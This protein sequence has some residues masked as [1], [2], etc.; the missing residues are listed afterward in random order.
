MQ[1]AR[2]PL[3]HLAAAGVSG[4]EKEDSTAMDLHDKRSLGGFSRGAG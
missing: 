3:G 4:A 2:P 1:G